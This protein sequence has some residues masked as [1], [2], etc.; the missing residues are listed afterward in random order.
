QRLRFGTLAPS[1]IAAVLEKRHEY[2]AAEAHAAAAGADGSIG[3][4]LEGSSDEYAE[5]REAAAALLAGVGSRVDP[6]SRLD[7]ARALTGG[8]GDREEVGRRLRA[9]ASL[10]RDVGVLLSRADERALAN[11]DLK[12]LLLR[13]T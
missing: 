1:E 4:A 2:S 9:A 12:P 10:L 8:S 11:A 5:A 3:R 7:N 6:R 13:L